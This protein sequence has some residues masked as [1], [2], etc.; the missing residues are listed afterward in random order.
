MHYLFDV[1][2]TLTPS[3]GKINPEFGDWFLAFANTHPVSLVSGSDYQK[4]IDQLGC[5]IIAA[6]K[7][8]FS[9][10]G[11]VVRDCGVIVHEHKWDIPGDAL[12]YLHKAVY[13][14]Q[15]PDRYGKHFERRTGMLNVSVVGRNATGRE[16]TDYYHWDLVHS[17]RANIAKSINQK[18]PALVAVVGGETSIDISSIGSDKSQVLEWIVGD[19][20]FFGDRMDPIGNDYPLAAAI[21]AENRGDSHAVRGWQNTWH[22]LKSL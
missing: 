1:D 2:G 4:T 18:W 6:T 20:A 14:S 22:L 13:T 9:C 10:S 12:C 19:I 5:E 11:N 16:R 7:F 15:Y 8:V 21:L 17:E 3:R